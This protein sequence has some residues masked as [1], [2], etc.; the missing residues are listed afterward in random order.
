MKRI[1]MIALVL[2]VALAG[3]A[4]QSWQF[5]ILHTNDLHGWMLPFDYTHDNAQFLQ[6][7]FT[8]PAYE[9]RDAG[10][11][12]RRAT[13]IAQLR[14]ETD[15]ALALI[16]C[17]DIFTRGP[18]HKAGL[19]FGVPETEALNLMG[20]DMLCVG[21]NEFK[22][23]LGADSQAIL[24]GL[25]RRSR[26]PWL[27]ANLTV[28]ETGV[29]VEG[30]HPYIVREY[31][32]V[33]VAFL[34]LTAP[35]AKDYPQTAGWRIDDPIAAAKR[36]VPLARK[37]CD[38]LIAVTHIGTDLDKQLAAAVPGIDAII[39]GDSHTFI[40][41]PLMIKNP[42][43]MEVPIVQTGAYGIFLGKLDLTFEQGDVWRLVK[44]EGTLIPIDKSYADDPAIKNLLERYKI[45]PLV[46]VG[47]TPFVV[48]AWGF[49][50]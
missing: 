11:L 22:A 44:T 2:L 1:T 47:R 31:Q 24:L 3:W 6:F 34:G 19:S 32:G 45:Q 16:D 25:M 40:P 20:Y 10:G 28:A 9:R 23:T 7:E 4:G 26:F 38:V 29:P 36:W 18:W 30:V 12:A 48:P 8:D 33:R 46:K 37:E 27:A 14:K 21:N 17:G 42:A 13:A 39:G 35:R 43:G 49:A 41:T 5:T 15:H 50:A